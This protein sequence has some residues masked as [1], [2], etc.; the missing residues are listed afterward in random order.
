MMYTEICEKSQY[1]DFSVTM[2]GLERSL[3]HVTDAVPGTISPN[4]KQG[5][6][7]YYMSMPPS[8]PGMKRHNLTLFTHQIAAAWGNYTAAREVHGEDRVEPHH[9]QWKPTHDVH[10]RCNMGNMGCHNFLHLAV[11]PRSVNMEHRINCCAYMM[12]PVCS[13]KIRVCHEQDPSLR[14]LNIRYELCSL[15]APEGY[16]EGTRPF[17][18]NV[19]S[20]RLPTRRVGHLLKRSGRSYVSRKRKRRKSSS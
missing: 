8:G 6:F 11:V 14:C 10:H 15:C 16:P 20:S 1:H 17:G 7:M 18:I 19:V 13:T 9:W 12:C 2:P 4:T 3:C 5:R